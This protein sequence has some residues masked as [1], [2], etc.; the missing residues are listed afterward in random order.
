M[1]GLKQSGWKILFNLKIIFEFYS[2]CF[3][4]SMSNYYIK[5]YIKILMCTL[6]CTMERERGSEGWAFPTLPFFRVHVSFII[7][8][9]GSGTGPGYPTDPV[10]C[11]VVADN[12]WYIS[13]EGILAMTGRDKLHFHL[14][15]ARNRG[16]GNCCP[17][18]HLPNPT[19]PSSLEVC[20]LPSH[21]GLKRGTGSYKTKVLP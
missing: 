13:S 18:P 3:N 21:L 16:W 11:A 14:A 4:I 6:H 9:R 17:T 20:L 5:K 8:I 2:P 12:S 15:W 1:F 19:R 10:F 7:K